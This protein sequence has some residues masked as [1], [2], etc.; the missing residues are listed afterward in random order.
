MADVFQERGIDK[1][2]VRKNRIGE[3]NGSNAWAGLVKSVGRRSDSN[4]IFWLSGVET[5]SDADGS[6]I[7]AMEVASVEKSKMEFDIARAAMRERSF[8]CFL[9]DSVRARD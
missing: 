1:P 3:T 7:C 2:V 5:E 8:G 4:F 6:E 9:R